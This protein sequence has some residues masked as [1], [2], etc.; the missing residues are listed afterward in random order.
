MGAIVLVT[1]GCRSGKSAAAQ[2]LAESLPGPRVFLATSVALD[3]E[4]QERVRLHRVARA[5]GGWSTIEEPQDL[6]GAISSAPRGA[7]V[8]VD[9]LA[10]WV[11][12][13]HLAKIGFFGHNNW[14]LFAIFRSGA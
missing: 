2:R 14:V 8:L 11:G 4:M 12:R 3:A 7:V 5:A 10:V 6:V 9:C 1:G 13:I